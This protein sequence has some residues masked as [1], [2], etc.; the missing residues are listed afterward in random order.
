M[1]LARFNEMK[2]RGFFNDRVAATRAV[3]RG[4]PPPIELGPN[5]VAWDLDEAEAYVAALPR[6]QKRLPVEGEAA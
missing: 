1:R 3:K 4:F 6:R 2:E 5:T